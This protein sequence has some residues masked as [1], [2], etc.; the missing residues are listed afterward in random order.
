[1]TP[2]RG[3]RESRDESGVALIIAL[4]FVVGIGVVLTALV[5]L[6][7]TNLTTTVDLQQQRNIEF[8]ADAGIEGAIQALRHQ[9][10]SSLTSPTCPSYPSSPSTSLTINGVTMDV[11]CSMSI[12]AGFYGRLVE[13]DACQIPAATFA[14]CQAAAAV[15]VEVQFDDVAPGCSSGA[16]PGCYGSSWGTGMTIETWNVRTA[17]A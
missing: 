15:R 4:V 2:F 17:D 13:F 7:G 3:R 11:A 16:N 10:P 14:A 9:A 8:A 12:P 5:S 1:M 6:T